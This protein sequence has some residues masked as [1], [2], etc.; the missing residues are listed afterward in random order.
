[1]GVNSQTI[2]KIIRSS[3]CNTKS[4]AIE[5]MGV[6]ATWMRILGVV[7]L[8]TVRCAVAT[9]LKDIPGIDARNPFR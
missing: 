1:M 3:R 7:V 5:P 6:A 2:N 9:F 4:G 8:C